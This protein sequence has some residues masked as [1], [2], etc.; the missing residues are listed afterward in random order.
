MRKFLLVVPFFLLGSFLAVAQGDFRPGYYITL[1][2]D[3][4]SALIDYR[5]NKASSKKVTYKQTSK[6]KAKRFFPGEILAYGFDNGR[7]F[8]SKKIRIEKGEPEK[9][10]FIEQLVAGKLSLLVYHGTYFA[11]KDSI[12]KLTKDIQDAIKTRSGASAIVTRKP[13][14][15]LLNYLM[16]D[17]GL[18]ADGARYERRKMIDLV[19]SYNRC[20]D[21]THVVYNTDLQNIKFSWQLFAGIDNSKLIPENGEIDFQKSSTALYG[22]GF[23][24]SSPRL[25]DRLFFTVEAQYSEKDYLGYYQEGVSQISR[26]DIFLDA[27]ALRIATGVK[28]NFSNDAQTPYIKFGCSYAVVSD[29]NIK[30]LREHEFPKGVVSTSSSSLSLKEKNQTA[31]W[32]SVGF[33]QHVYGRYKGFVEVRIERPSGFTKNFTDLE[34]ASITNVSFLLGVRF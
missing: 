17:C 1:Q 20:K 5:S 14:I 10:I 24:V 33:T 4:V 29:A 28:Y 16:H 2:H 27:K 11:E 9:L 30:F 25:F 15:G 31:L 34:F 18:S 23:D 22:L 3:S 32:A 19:S 8:I 6:S 26:Y 13:Y 7:R 21:A 12:Y